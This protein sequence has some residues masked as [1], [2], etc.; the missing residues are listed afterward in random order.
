LN[1][2]VLFT[3][4]FD[5]TA[6]TAKL[7][8]TTFEPGDAIMLIV[9][10]TE[11]DRATAAIKSI[12]GLLGM[13]RSRGLSL[14]L[15]VVTINELSFAESVA[16]IYNE[17]VTLGA[18]QIEIDASGGLRVLGLAAYTTAMLLASTHPDLRPNIRFTLRL[19]SNGIETR[20]I[21]PSLPTQGYPRRA[22][23]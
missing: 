10:S 1:K 8:E 16:K 22:R 14:Q 19:E 18:A 17:V 7:V 2:I 9:P 23:S 21:L 6:I 12:E 3:L 4:G 13:L 11:S 15:R 5:T 20:A